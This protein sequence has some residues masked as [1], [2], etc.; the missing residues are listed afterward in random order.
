MKLLLD[1]QLPPALVLWLKVQGHVA[2]AVRE[3]GLREASDSQIW[4]HARRTS[5]VI[6]TKDE[7]F[8]ARAQQDVSGVT[9]V[10]LRIGNCSNAALQDWLELRLPGIT[11]LVEQG[12]HLVEVV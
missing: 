9:V 3:V 2:E 5:A 6:M 4:E 11:Q 10:W 1:A 7:D 12:S 8:A